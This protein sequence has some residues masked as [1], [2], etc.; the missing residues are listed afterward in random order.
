MTT[1]ILTTRRLDLERIGLRH[2]PALFHLLT[3]PAVHRHFPKT[4]DRAEAQALY[5]KIRQRYATD[6]YCFWAVMR[7]RDARFLGICGLLTQRIDGQREVEVG[8]RFSHHHWNR[9]YATEAAKGCMDYARDRLGLA[10]IISLI[11]PAN[12]PSI[13]VAEKNG[14]RL[15]KETR[16]HG[17]PHLVY[18]RCLD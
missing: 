7:K 12:R 13:R 4:P 11:R 17:L 3:D 9:G 8:Y 10:S 15:E 14:L 5:E 1:A 2:Q 18:R 16:F 6:G